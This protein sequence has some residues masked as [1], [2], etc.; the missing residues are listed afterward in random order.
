MA[1]LIYSAQALE[2]LERLTDFLMSTEP[3]AATAT[4][5]LVSEAI[6]VLGNHPFIGRSVEN[7]LRELV[8]SRGDSGY[9]A[10][11]GHEHLQDLV[12]VPTIRHQRE[13]GY[14]DEQGTC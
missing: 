2:D 4:V 3:T 5:E 1:R 8:I 9:I 6:E 7:G 11:Y 14:T 10:L 12:L 13:A